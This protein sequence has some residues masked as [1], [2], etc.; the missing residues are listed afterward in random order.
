MGDS[1]HGMDLRRSFYW[2]SDGNGG[3][4]DKYD[5]QTLI[6]DWQSVFFQNNGVA[7]FSSMSNLTIDC[8]V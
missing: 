2:I 4:C 1:P 6:A 8:L 5:L 3:F 7:R